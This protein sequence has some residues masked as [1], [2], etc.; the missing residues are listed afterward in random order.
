MAEENLQ[1]KTEKATPRR[2]ER[3]RSKGQVAKSREIPSV[4]VLFAGISVLYFCGSHMCQNLM[5]ISRHFFAGSGGLKLI[6]PDIYILCHQVFKR[7]FIIMAP[8]MG[9]VFA[10]AVA[11]NM[12][13]FGFVLSGQSITP[14]INKLN[15][16]NGFQR[17]FSKQGLMELLKSLAKVAVV[18]CV[19]FLTIKGE[20]ANLVPMMDKSIGQ[21]VRYMG[22]VSLKIFFLTCVVLVVLAAID[23]AF[24]KWQ[25]EKN[26]RMTKQEAKEEFRQTEGD[27]FIKA[28][29]RS[30]Q[31]E[32]AR[33]RM[34]KA[35]PQ[36]DVVITNPIHL[37]VALQ[38][39]S[40][41]MEAPKVV[42]KGAGIIAEKIQE[43]AR[44]SGVPIVQN[45]PLAQAL[46]RMVEIGELI[47]TT[48]Y[49]AVAE[50]LAYVYKIKG[51][52][53]G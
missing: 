44:T 36:A 6:E 50:V 18:G 53:I 45:K 35:V 49:K 20:L 17:I 30:L 4:M 22:M 31:R 11:A 32:M 42:A 46:Y 25:F 38:Y 37:A 29:I 21:I 8:L 51:K 15:P 34:M 33:R 52:H 47:P 27:P 7:F 19:A 3:A 26:L 9:S 43:I 24:Q 41:Q 39:V 12:V 48:L 2:R 28:R 16:V 5:M 13:Q 23:Y 14:D 1:D 40:G 10:V